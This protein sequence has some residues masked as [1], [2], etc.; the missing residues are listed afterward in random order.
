VFDFDGL[1]LE[2]ER[3]DYQSWREV[4]LEHGEELT[5]DV[6]GD[7]IG[8]GASYFDPYQELVAK[9]GHDLDRETVLNRRKARHLEMIA[10]LEI[11]PGIRDAVDDATRLGIR[12]GVASSSSRAW[13]TGHLERLGLA[14][15]FDCVRCR[16]D[17]ANTKPDPELYLSVCAC[18]GVAPGDAV[19]LEDSANGI[20]AAKAA[21]MRCVAIPNPMTAGL[22][23]S[24][25][26]LRLGSLADVS[27]AELLE[28]LA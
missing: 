6:W 8:R 11:L 25:A 12:L 9:L 28:R 27:V 26:D 7:V 24:A 19:A 2:T 23:L 1:I 18:L 16:D 20:A 17:V 21:G 5:M 3:P 13:V 4:Y 22:D 10:E 14:A 15:S